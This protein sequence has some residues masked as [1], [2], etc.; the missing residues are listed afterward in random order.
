MTPSH[1]SEVPDTLGIV[2]RATA[3]LEAGNQDPDVTALLH[4]PEALHLWCTRQMP[5][6]ELWPVAR[7]QELTQ[8]RTAH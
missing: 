6:Y 5:E 4:N 1:S 8:K 3:A 7:L 2:K